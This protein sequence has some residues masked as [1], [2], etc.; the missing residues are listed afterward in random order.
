MDLEVLE[1]H[2]QYIDV[3]DPHVKSEKMM[4]FVKDIFPALKYS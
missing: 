2:M 1:R 3:L 4:H